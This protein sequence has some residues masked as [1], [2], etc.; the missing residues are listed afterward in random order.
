MKSKGD[1][2]LQSHDADELLHEL[3]ILHSEVH[4]QNSRSRIFMNGIISGLGRT[5][6][7]TIVFAL[8]ITILSYIITTSNAQ[9]VRDLLSWLGLTQYLNI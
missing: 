3:E 2:E 5:I 1:N 8:L 9:W 7:A 4:K 6:G